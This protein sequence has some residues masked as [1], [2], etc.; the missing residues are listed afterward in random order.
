ME[1]RKEHFAS[2]V[3]DHNL[4]RIKNSLSQS[5][6]SGFGKYRSDDIDELSKA[7]RFNS[8]RVVQQGAEGASHH[9]G[10][11]QIVDLFD[12]PRRNRPS[13]FAVVLVGPRFIPDIPFVERK[14]H[15]RWRPPLR[16]HRITTRHSFFDNAIHDFAAYEEFPYIV[17]R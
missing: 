10:I 5:R 9:Q 12:Q 3:L 14:H 8:I 7:S 13:G 1:F 17:M 4:E 15:S 11:L 6:T 2:R 16:C